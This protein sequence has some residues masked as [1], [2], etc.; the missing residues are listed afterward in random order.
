MTDIVI[1]SRYGM[2]VKEGVA[3]IARSNSYRQIGS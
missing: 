3:G 1:L 2:S